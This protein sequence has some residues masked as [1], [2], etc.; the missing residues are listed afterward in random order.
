MLSIWSAWS[1]TC[2][3][4]MLLLGFAYARWVRPYL[5]SLLSFSEAYERQD[6][7]WAAVKDWLNGRKVVLVG[8]WGQIIAF[9]PD[10]LQQIAGL[11]LKYLLGLPDL[12]AA[13]VSAVIPLLMLILRARA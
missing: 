12:W 8:I 6:A 4:L 5:Q 3:L 2:V 9:G 7:F 1:V 11:D 10:A 13:W